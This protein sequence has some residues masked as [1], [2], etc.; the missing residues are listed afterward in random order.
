M[1]GV[2]P[3][4]QGQRPW[5]RDVEAWVGL[6]HLP[7]CALSNHNAFSPNQAGVVA[8]EQLRPVLLSWTDC[9]QVPMRSHAVFPAHQVRLMPKVN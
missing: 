1:V 9:V 8:G 3:A 7:Q 5:E 6:H 4:L 2:W